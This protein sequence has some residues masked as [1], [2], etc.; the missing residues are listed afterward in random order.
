MASF[1]KKLNKKDLAHFK[2]MTDHGRV[3]LSALKAALAHQK[4]KG[5][6]CHECN[7]LARKLG[8]EPVSQS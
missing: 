8:L 7:A 2:D 5:T 6:I 4:E 3:T 1:K